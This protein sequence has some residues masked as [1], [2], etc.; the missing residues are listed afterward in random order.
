MVGKVQLLRY[1]P[2]IDINEVNRQIDW[3]TAPKIQL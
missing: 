3:P 1:Y 2:Y